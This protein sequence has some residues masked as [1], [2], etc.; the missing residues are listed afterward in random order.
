MVSFGVLSLLSFMSIMVIV[1][2]VFVVSA[3]VIIVFVEL[4]YLLWRLFLPFYC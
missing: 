3:D 4:P 2:V 1:V